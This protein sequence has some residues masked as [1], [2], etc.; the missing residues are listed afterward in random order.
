[1]ADVRNNESYTVINPLNVGYQIYASIT[2]HK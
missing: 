1:M 2:Q